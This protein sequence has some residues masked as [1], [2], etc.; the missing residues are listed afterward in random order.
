MRRK[1]ITVT[2]PYLPPLEEFIP[3]LEQIWES[4]TLTNNGPFHVQ[5]E[6]ALCDYFGVEHLALFAN[7][8]I[9]LITALQT[10]RISGEVITTPYSFVAT[11]HSLLW[12]TITPVFVDIDPQRMSLDPDRD[13]GGNHARAPP[14][15]CRCIA[16]ATPATSSASSI[17]PTPMA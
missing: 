12:N 6:Q 5:L 7:G 10:L 11:S 14:P 2:Q 16:M 3:Y 9:A 8:T 15:S 17:L 4:K 1:P 13:R